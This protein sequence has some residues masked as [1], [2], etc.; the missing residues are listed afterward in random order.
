MFNIHTLEWD[1]DILKFA[2]ISPSMLCELKE[3]TYFAPLKDSMAE[4]LGIKSGIPVIIGGSDGA[5]N[6][7]GA[8]ALKRGIMTLSVGLAERS[9]W[10]ITNRCYLKTDPPGAI[11]A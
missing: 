1:E 2:G 5:L 6:Q 7:I 3:A 11:T 4:L 8:G 10:R 9:G